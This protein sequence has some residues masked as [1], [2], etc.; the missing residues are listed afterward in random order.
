MD[1]YW[2]FDL[3]DHF[4]AF[5]EVRETIQR[6]IVPHCAFDIVTRH[7]LYSF[8]D[9]V[10]P[11]MSRQNA[12]SQWVVASWICCL[13]VFREADLR[14][15]SCITSVPHTGSSSMHTQLLHFPG[16]KCWGSLSCFQDCQ[17]DLSTSHVLL[18]ASGRP[19]LSLPELTWIVHSRSTI[20]ASP[21]IIRSLRVKD[22]TPNF[23]RVCGAFENYV[24][25]EAESL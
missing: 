7:E 3:R 21:S 17:K 12:L 15:L 23:N 4:F 20:K 10:W 19:S 2:K 22:I 6:H 1:E 16:G 8:Y 11:V 25:E 9:M 14:N 5:P 13:R 18:C 24:A